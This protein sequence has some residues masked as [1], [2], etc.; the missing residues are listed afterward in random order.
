[1]IM[2]EALAISHIDKKIILMKAEGLT[3]KEIC[4]KVDLTKEAVDKRI[5]RLIERFN[6]ESILHLYKTMKEQG[7]I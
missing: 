2:S 3:S 4:D 1:M 6:C 5:S 7:Y